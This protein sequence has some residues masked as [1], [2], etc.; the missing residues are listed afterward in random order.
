MALEAQNSVWFT[1]LD[2]VGE[3]AFHIQTRQ[4]NVGRHLE[5]AQISGGG[6]SDIIAS[7][8]PN[9]T[10]LPVVSMAG[11]VRTDQL[12]S[13]SP[14]ALEVKLQERRDGKTALPIRRCASIESQSNSCFFVAQSLQ[15][16]FMI[17]GD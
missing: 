15:T 12:P 9:R 13:P 3:P 8:G 16:N 17:E 7:V 5:V 4:T 6:H 2:N 11:G 1:I 14:P 10:Y